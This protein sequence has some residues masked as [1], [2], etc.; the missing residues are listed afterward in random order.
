MKTTE[1][2]AIEYAVKK[3]KIDNSNPVEIEQQLYAHELMYAFQAG[4]EFAQRWIPV[5]EDLPCIG[6]NREVVLVKGFYEIKKNSRLYFT[7]SSGLITIDENGTLIWS[8][9]NDD[10]PEIFFNCVVTHWRPIEYK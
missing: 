2:A 3:S 7:Q 4:V 5:E 9:I 8:G 1:E 10:E 6:D